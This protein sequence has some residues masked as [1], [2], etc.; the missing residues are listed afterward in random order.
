MRVAP[1]TVESGDCHTC[2]LVVRAV[3]R[4]AFDTDLADV[5]KR[6][7]IVR[8]VGDTRVSEESARNAIASV[9]LAYHLREIGWIKH[10]H[11]ESVSRFEAASIP[12]IGPLDEESARSLARCQELVDSQCLVRPP[13]LN[14]PYTPW[15]TGPSGGL[16]LKY[17][18]PDVRPSEYSPTRTHELEPDKAAVLWQTI[19]EEL[20]AGWATT[21]RHVQSAGRV[22]LGPKNRFIFWPKELNRLLA[23]VT[24]SYGRVVDL[25]SVLALYGV[26]LD[27]KSAYRALRID[28]DDVPFHGAIVDAVHV[29]FERLSFGMGQSPVMFTCAL[30]VTIDAYRDSMPATRAALAQF[31]DDS[32]LG[33]TS[34]GITIHAAEQLLRALKA[35]GWWL[36][37]AKTYLW[38]TSTLSYTGFLVDFAARSVCV[39]P[40][41]AAKVIDLLREIQRPTDAAL[42]ADAA[43]A[44]AAAAAPGLA[45]APLDPHHDVSQHRSQMMT[46]ALQRP[47]FTTLAIGH[48]IDSDFG[49]RHV[50]ARIVRGPMPLAPLDNVSVVGSHEY[51]CPSALPRAI[52]SASDAA[53]NDQPPSVVIAILP[54][55]RHPEVIRAI[56]ADIHPSVPVVACAP[57]PAATATPTLWCDPSLR[58]PSHVGH[59]QRR[60]LP[61][62]SALPTPPTQSGT[63]LDL[64]GPEYDA[65]RRAQ[66]Y[67]SW[68]QVAVPFLG[69]WRASVGGLLQTGRWNIERAAAFDAIYSV[70]HVLG[71]FRFS[72]DPPARR[73][74][75]VTDASGVGW[76]AVVHA[77][78]KA[79]HFAGALPPDVRIGSSTL[80][81][82]TAAVC[83]IRCA[84]TLGVAFDGVIVRTDSTALEAAGNGRVRSETV[85]RSLWPLAA[86]AV[87][88]LRVEFEW[89]SRSHH[90]HA[91][92]DALSAVVGPSPWPLSP[93][94]ASRVWDFAGGWDIDA[95]AYGGHESSMA[96]AYAT[97]ALSD[98]S[99]STRRSVLA[100]IRVD[101]TVGWQGLSADLDV[102]SGR[103]AFA[104]P[105]W[106]HLRDLV[107][108]WRSHPCRLVVIAPRV[109][110]KWWAPF[111]ADLDSCTTRSIDLDPASTIPPVPGATRDPE[112]LAARLLMPSIPGTAP[113]TPAPIRAAPP[114][115]PDWYVPAAAGSRP[116]PPRSL[117][118]ANADGTGHPLSVSDPTPQPSL[119]AAAAA[120]RAGS[121]SGPA[122][123][124]AWAPPAPQHPVTTAT[125]RVSGWADPCGAGAAASSTWATPTTATPIIAPPP[126][127]P[128]PVPADPRQY[129]SAQGTPAQLAWT[130]SGHCPKDRPWQ[131]LRTL[132]AGRAP[133]PDPPVARR[134]ARPTTARA[135]QSPRERAPSRA[136]GG[137]AASTGLRGMLASGALACAPRSSAAAPAGA[138]A[139]LRPATS[140][141]LTAAPDPNAPP[142]AV[143]AFAPAA[144]PSVRPDR[145]VA[146]AAGR[147]AP[148]ALTCGEWLRSILRYHGGRPDTPAS[149]AIAGH[150]H[151]VR[152]AARTTAQAAVQGSSATVSVP[153]LAL[154]FAEHR[155]VTGAAWSPQRVEAFV[156]DFCQT[157]SG[158]S[159]ASSP[160]KA[161]VTV[162]QAMGEASTLA[163]ASRRA[164]HAVPAY[165]GQLVDDWCT[166]EGGRAKPEHST[167]YPLHLAH[168]LAAEPSATTKAHE[169]WK[170][171]ALSSF[172][173]LRTGVAQHL[174]SHMFVPYDGGW[175]CVWRFPHKRTAR[176]DSCDPS[177]MSAIGAI[178]AARHPVLDRILQ[179]FAEC[180]EN[181]RICPTA[182]CATMS[183]FVRDHLPGAP[184]SFNMRGYGVRTGADHD[185]TLL[186]VPS[187]VVD[188]LFCWKR[189]GAT[190]RMQHYYSGINIRH[191]FAFTERRTRINFRHL[192]AGRFAGTVPD[193]SFLDWDS[194]VVA[195]GPLPD[196][197]SFT[198]IGRALNAQAPSLTVAKQVRATVRRVR[199]RR[200]AGES[201]TDSEASGSV[202]G[203]LEAVCCVC[204]K[205]LGPSDRASIC[206]R[207]PLTACHQ[208]A[209]P[210]V[211]PYY[212]PGHA[213]ARPKRQ[214]RST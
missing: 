164:G 170:G 104:Y 29:C 202:E 149:A 98:A 91:R 197:P 75:V 131:G 46:R 186:K 121:T 19:V 138:A 59:P 72:V 41:K 82:A 45:P 24:V 3:L 27:I 39:D 65:L 191:M 190:A 1:A 53:A 167:A 70:L 205:P 214:R 17:A 201:S 210:R 64:T 90:S 173:C 74:C 81:E 153:Q 10:Q 168:I 165:C 94:A 154:A 68:F 96:P 16:R 83:A 193:R 213:R 171:L 50:N 73:I 128:A 150:E 140:R 51:T 166:A 78:G 147:A 127:P 47:G 129:R 141:T 143:G 54:P 5:I 120:D 35:D 126:V 107:S 145:S 25:L 101:S 58:L 124:S 99:A 134:S 37:A 209:D 180:K 30:A 21:A 144:A 119:S 142:P 212:C 132:L 211:Q 177:K 69:T 15:D 7:G 76:G 20:A 178:S 28:P 146:T 203:T 208:C 198:I 133:S 204:A 169:V 43:A 123:A 89:Q 195:K 160:W 4:A 63:R 136:P 117:P 34:I 67:M 106:S 105:L 187:A 139:T 137:G 116:A 66:G 152:D 122:P 100:G 200:A 55:G 181:T 155:R 88:G 85:A 14:L 179:P 95:M 61:A 113:P 196:L 60:P 125:S 103:T 185:A 189:S 86:W 163:A 118:T 161:T 183:K 110:R 159:S 9:G 22:F 26:K 157:R 109:G 182:T 207:C 52:A 84:L 199:A 108:W 57:D 162:A 77:N 97:P 112:P 114:P 102:P 33:G 174:Y 38:P 40:A 23:R 2:S 12:F 206:S 42:A 115:L 188:T 48:P 175:L 176:V 130:R 32:G 71:N 184:P 172:F 79:V 151:A 148:C 194:P 13:D 62:T 31:V 56:T 192:F 36:A 93:E 111:I 49:Q 158:K 87:Q 156:L 80:R 6:H 8:D 135:A 18:D 44:A 11:R 92:P